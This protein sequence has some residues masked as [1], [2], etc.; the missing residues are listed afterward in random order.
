MERRGFEGNLIPDGLE[1]LMVWRRKRRGVE[2]GRIFSDAGTVQRGLLSSV[3]P[4]VWLSG[5]P[6]NG[7]TWQ[8]ATRIQRSRLEH[9]PPCRRTNR[10][11]R[12]FRFVYFLGRTGGTCRRELACEG[13]VKCRESQGVFGLTWLLALDF[14]P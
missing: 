4:P 13:T 5:Q 2:L 11:P 3:G 9:D 1:H 14:V 10:S 7:T 8:Q 12:G 6:Q